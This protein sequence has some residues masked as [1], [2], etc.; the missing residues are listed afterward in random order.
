MKW[1]TSGFMAFVAVC[2]LASSACSSTGLSENVHK[3][4]FSNGL[5]VLVK[6]EP[7]SGLVAISVIIRAG[8]LEEEH[9]PGLGQVLS[10]TL[11]TGA[12]NLSG[13]KLAELSDEVGGSFAVT[14]DLDFTE[15]YIATTREQLRPALEILSEILLHPRFDPAVVET[16]RQEVETQITSAREAAFRASYDELRRLLYLESPYRRALLGSSRA[17]DGITPADLEKFVAQWFVP[18]NMVIAVVGDVTVEETLD[19]ARLWFSSKPAVSTPTRDIPRREPGLSRPP[20]LL[21]V[22]TRASYVVA[23]TLAA[24]MG[25]EHYGADMVVATVLGGGKSSRMFQELREKRGLAYE[26]GTLYPPLIYQSH[27]VAYVLAAPYEAIGRGQ[28]QPTLEAIRAGLNET[29]LSLRDTPITQAELNR[30]KR[31][32]IGRFI[33]RHQRLNE[34]ARHLAWYESLGLGFGYDERYP[35]IIESVTLEQ[36]QRSADRLFRNSSMVLVVPKE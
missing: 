13:R 35:Q 28:S 18:S 27:L 7:G 14:W 24:G 1:F 33:L 32:L 19:G 4:T 31:Y 29:V 25:D 26:L 8:A 6:P 12:K 17:V 9:A 34:R 20:S 16:A 30:A 36:A 21:E 10:R 3:N 15:V 5:R 2:L 23:G 11:F 22:D